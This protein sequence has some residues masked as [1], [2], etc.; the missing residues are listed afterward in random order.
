MSNLNSV[1]QIMYSTY[2]P[3]NKRQ[4]TTPATVLLP[5]SR[6]LYLDGTNPI[7][8]YAF[9]YDS[10]SAACSPSYQI[11]NRS[12]TSAEAIFAGQALNS[13]I[14]V[15][16]PDY[17]GPLG[18]FNVGPL[19]GNSLLDAVRAVLDFKAAVPDKRKAK[20]V[21]KGYSG[22]SV[23]VAWAVQQQPSYAPELLPYL[24]G[25]SMGGMPTMPSSSL[26]ALNGG[27][28]S[29]LV[30]SALAAYS[31]VFGSISSWVDA[32]LTPAGK[33]AIA[34]AEQLCT[35]DNL[36]AYANTDVFQK[37][38]G[39]SVNQAIADPTVH[40]VL[41]FLILANGDDFGVP[42]VPL[43]VY[44]SKQDDTIPHAET[45]RYVD[46]LCNRGVGS[47]E[48]KQIATGGHVQTEILTGPTDAFAFLSAR[49]GGVLQPVK[50]CNATLSN[51]AASEKNF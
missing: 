27:Q 7:L 4:Y 12:L 43:F 10:A 41:D 45:Q 35:A 1:Q 3:I 15:V 11:A 6:G 36:T 24:K 5:S 17:E 34:D 26:K 49:L 25:A 39:T 21:L 28:Y 37:Y 31:N 14:T 8:V 18:A 23:P 30:L 9:A 46:A 22:G 32:R 2:D 42:Q 13:G 38:V 16:L 50:G 40:K 47:L 48:Y 20:V 44:S 33:A 51:P 29:T 19:S